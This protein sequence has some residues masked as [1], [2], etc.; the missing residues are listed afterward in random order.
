MLIKFVRSARV[1]VII[2]MGTILNQLTSNF[3]SLNLCERPSF[4][5]FIG[6]RGQSTTLSKVHVYSVVF[7][8]LY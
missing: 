7:I 6:S 8:G 2:I 1:E 5:P 4:Q 3:T